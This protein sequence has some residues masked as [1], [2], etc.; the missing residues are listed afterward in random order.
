VE[1]DLAAYFKMGSIKVVEAKETFSIPGELSSLSRTCK[2]KV[3]RVLS[4]S[5][6]STTGFVTKDTEILYREDG[7]EEEKKEGE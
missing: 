7:I 1:A 4:S 5:G 3:D 2:F 6:V